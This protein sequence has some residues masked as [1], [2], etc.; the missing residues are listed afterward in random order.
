MREITVYSNDR[1]SLKPNVPGA[2]MWAVGLDKAGL[3]EVRVG[4]KDIGYHLTNAGQWWDIV[5][6]AGLR[7]FVSSLS[8]KDLE[9]FRDEHLK[10]IE[11]L[12]TGNGI[13]LEVKALYVSGIKHR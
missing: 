11:S 2:K 10:D 9:K 6:N 3:T 5:W 8:N 7:R 4:T 1:L 12:S 13:W